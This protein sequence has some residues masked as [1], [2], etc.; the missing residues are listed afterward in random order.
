MEGQI[1]DNRA[2]V[3]RLGACRHRGAGLHPGCCGHQ[4]KLGQR[5]DMAWLRLGFCVEKKLPWGG[6][7]TGKRAERETSK[8]AGP[9]S[10]LE[11]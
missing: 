10:G 8:E 5:S 1:R 7:G 2:T 9:S 11:S 3:S 6:K 4:E